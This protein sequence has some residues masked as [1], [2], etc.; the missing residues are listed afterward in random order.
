MGDGGAVALVTGRVVIAPEVPPFDGATLHVYLEDVSRADA[1]STVLAETAIPGVKHGKMARGNKSNKTS[2]S[3]KGQSGT[4]VPFE[5]RAHPDAA[6]VDPRSSYSVRVWV[7]M[8]G[9]G[10]R[11]PGDLYSDQSYPV[12]TQGFGHTATIT[13][14][15]R[16]RK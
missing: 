8:D 5:L 6:P 12:L 10:K 9:D 2:K 14:T 11:G 16:R 4:V 7:D 3:G 13:L 1:A 15:A